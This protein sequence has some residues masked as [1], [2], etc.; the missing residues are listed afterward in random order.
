MNL[1]HVGHKYP[2]IQ[3]LTVPELFGSSRLFL[4]AYAL[5]EDFLELFVMFAKKE[6]KWRVG[7]GRSSFHVL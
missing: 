4:T 2:R 7:L 5:T 6:G 1:Q 3:I